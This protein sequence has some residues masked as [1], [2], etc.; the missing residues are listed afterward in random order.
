MSTGAERAWRITSRSIR[1]IL[2][3]A[4][5]LVCVAEFL[6]SPGLTYVSRVR[7]RV[8][9]CAGHGHARQSTAASWAAFEAGS[10]SPSAYRG[11]APA[12]S[13]GNAP[14]VPVLTAPCS[15]ASHIGGA[16][17]LART[18]GDCS[19]DSALR[20]LCSPDAQVANNISSY[21]PVSETTLRTPRRPKLSDK[22]AASLESGEISATLG[23]YAHWLSSPTKRTRVR[24]LCSDMP[25]KLVT[26]M[27]SDAAMVIDA[28]WLARG[29]PAHWDP[30][31]YAGEDAGDGA[32]ETGDELPRSQEDVK[33]EDEL[34]RSFGE[35]EVEDGQG[36]RAE[37][38]D[39]AGT[40]DGEGARERD[41]PD[42][43]PAA[44][45]APGDASRLLDDESPPGWVVLPGASEGDV[46]TSDPA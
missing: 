1:C 39:A 6:W 33:M 37:L 46:D 5:M 11:H 23:A 24:R 25:S 31:D 36:E 20:N 7:I 32:S 40:R 15:P 22:L 35:M 42:A 16:A 10:A 30:A 14:V 28:D 4:R 27:F 8:L 18:K 2:L 34:Q 29:E 17:R 3:Y 19:A 45:G 38:G 21:T 41:T 9:E 44:E 13:A 43:L 12:T 26:N